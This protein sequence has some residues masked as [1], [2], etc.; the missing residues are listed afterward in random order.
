MVNDWQN[1]IRQKVVTSSVG[2]KK[3][4]WGSWPLSCSLQLLPRYLR[5]LCPVAEKGSQLLWNEV[6]IKEISEEEEW[7]S[8][9]WQKDDKWDLCMLGTKTPLRKVILTLHLGHALSVLG[10]GGTMTPPGRQC[11]RSWLPTQEIKRPEFPTKKWAHT[12]LRF[13][14]GHCPFSFL[15]I[16]FTLKWSVCDFFS[17]WECC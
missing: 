1:R 17:L 14:G 11:G 9:G 6:A 12:V 3:A 7:V 10:E 15:L 8:P 4:S 5:L 16:S 13:K 2:A